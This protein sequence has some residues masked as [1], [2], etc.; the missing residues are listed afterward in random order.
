MSGGPRRYR[1]TA[2]GA[3]QKLRLPVLGLMGV[4]VITYSVQPSAVQAADMLNLNPD[5]L[6]QT[7]PVQEGPAI[8]SP[9][10]QACWAEG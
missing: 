5:L 9:T 7:P 10:K 4:A 2:S 3:E 1:S 6:H 8:K